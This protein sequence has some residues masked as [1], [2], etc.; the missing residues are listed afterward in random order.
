[1]QDSQIEEKSKEIP[2]M[3]PP[4]EEEIPLPKNAREAFPNMTP[5]EEVEARANTI[6]LMSDISGE[7]IEPSFENKKEA[8]ELAKD[9]VNN[10]GLKPEFANYP[11][12]TMAYLAGMVASSNC[13]IVKELADLKLYVVNRFVQEAETAKNSKDRLMALKAIGEVDGVDAFKK[14]TDY[15]P[16]NKT[17]AELER[18]LKEAIEQIKGRVIEAEV[19]EDKDD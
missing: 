3:V 19:I 18:E 13:M 11:N 17:G 6:K 15:Y 7:E 8:E 12:E 9:M 5:A 14:Q 10:P 2:T 16:Y 1:M 4:I